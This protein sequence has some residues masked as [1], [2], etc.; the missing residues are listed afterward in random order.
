MLYLCNSSN[1]FKCFKI[2][3]H[4]T[5][6]KNNIKSHKGYGKFYA[7]TIKAQKVN[8]GTIAK[9]IEHATTLSEADVLAA[10]KALS[11]SIKQH[12]QE[13]QT[14]D[15]GELGRFSIAVKSIP[16]DSPKAWNQKKNITGFQLVHHAQAHRNATQGR[17]L[18]RPLLDGC[19]AVRDDDAR[20]IE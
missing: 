4:Y 2:M 3:I 8:M 18:E 20:V 15:L 6:R 17:V 10:I 7:H 9:E 5:L 14:V 16:A 1:H 13:G 12:L 11:L 19:K